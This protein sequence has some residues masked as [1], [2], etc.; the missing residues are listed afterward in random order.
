MSIPEIFATETEGDT[1]VVTPGRTAG[2][3]TAATAR[4]EAER[5]D[6]QIHA[7][8]L[9]HVVMD[10]ENAEYFGTYMLELMHCLWRQVRG[11]GG[12]LVLCHVSEIGKEILHVARLDILWPSYA[13]RTEALKAAQR[14]R[15][16]P[17]APPPE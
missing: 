6:G 13:S 5:L 10:M 1:L 14:P 15:P 2:G 7:L 8:K 12:K 17:P 4:D 9:A 3:L 11:A 16:W